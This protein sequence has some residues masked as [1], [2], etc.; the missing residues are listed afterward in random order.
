MLAVVGLLVLPLPEH[1]RVRSDISVLT[2]GGRAETFTI[3]WPRDRIEIPPSSDARIAPIGPAV[4]LRAAER[5]HVAVEL[6][7]LRDSAG[8]IVG[9]ASRT[10][11][12]AAVAGGSVQGSDWMLLIPSRGALFLT[13]T[14]STDLLPRTV[15]GGAALIAATDQRTNWTST[16]HLQISAGPA[17]DGAGQILRGTQEFSGLSGV[18]RETWDLDESQAGPTSGRITLAT[19]L[20]AAAQ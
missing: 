15:N 18:F 6:F 2:N 11:S 10:I 7:R 16:P 12:H 17:A 19:E 9:V 13:E 20:H 4:A 5:S 3:Q 14:N 1:E 8:K